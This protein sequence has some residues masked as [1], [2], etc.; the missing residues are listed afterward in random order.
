VR[1][2]LEE[3]AAIEAARRGSFEDYLAS[4]LAD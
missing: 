3:F 4:Y 1:E 2:S